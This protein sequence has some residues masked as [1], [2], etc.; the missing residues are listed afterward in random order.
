MLGCTTE[1]IIVSF[2]PRFTAPEMLFCLPVIH[3]ASAA[4][5][6]LVPCT[7]VPRI[8][9]SLVDTSLLLCLFGVLWRVIGDWEGTQ[10]NSG[11]GGERERDETSQK[12]AQFFALAA[13]NSLG[14]SLKGH[15]FPQ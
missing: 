7:P 15:A 11:G 14:H 9:P 3:D 8:C 5:R 10:L 13:Q 4:S 12:Q 1:P 2:Y 6:C